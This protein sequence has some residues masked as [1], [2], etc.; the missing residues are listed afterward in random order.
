MMS[1]RDVAKLLTFVAAF[2]QRTV[3]EADVAAWFEI[4]TYGRWELPHA[5]RAVVEHYGSETDRIM[6]AHITRRLSER[7]QHFASTFRHEP[8]PTSVTDDIAWEREQVKAHITAEM[9][10]WSTGEQVRA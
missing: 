2:D 1:R 9:D 7:R 10:R 8:A 6:P 4:A 3:G 5:Q